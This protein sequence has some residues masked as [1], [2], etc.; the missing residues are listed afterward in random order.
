MAIISASLKSAARWL[1]ASMRLQHDG[2]QR[3]AFSLFAGHR[4]KSQIYFLSHATQ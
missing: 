2:L 1:S 4:F 3:I